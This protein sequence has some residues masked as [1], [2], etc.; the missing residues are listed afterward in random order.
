MSDVAPQCG[1]CRFFL[2]EPNGNSWC[3]RYPPSPHPVSNMVSG[4]Q[5]SQ[6]VIAYFPPMAPN[7]WCGEWRAEI[8]AVAGEPVV[9]F[10]TKVKP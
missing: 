1:N 5:M 9:P 10:P 8:A 6:G 3:R 7:G 4:V 2:R